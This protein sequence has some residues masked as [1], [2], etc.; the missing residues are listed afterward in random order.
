MSAPHGSAAEIHRLLAVAHNTAADQVLLR[1][2]PMLDQ[3]H[4]RSVLETLLQRRRSA[5]LTELVARCDQFSTTIQSD[6]Q[7]AVGKLEPAL[8]AA[9]QRDE[10]T[11]R[12]NAIRLIAQSGET[13]LM[14]LLSR[15]LAHRCPNTR[16]LAGKALLSFAER[17]LVAGARGGAGQPSRGSQNA[18]RHLAHA[19]TQALQSWELH[20]RPE[21]LIS[22]TALADLTESAIVDK[23]AQPRSRL[24]HAL[25]GLLSAPRDPR[26]APF[27]L[28]ALAI[29]ELRSDAARALSRCRNDAFMAAVIDECWVLKDPS[30]HRACA[31]VRE[32]QWLSESIDPLANLNRQQ[33]APSVRLIAA[34]GLPTDTK[35]TLLIDAF[36]QGDAHLRRAALWQLIAIDTPSSTS[37]LRRIAGRKGCPDTEIARRELQ[38]RRGFA[39]ALPKRSGGVASPSADVAANAQDALNVIFSDPEQTS[40]D[41]SSQALLGT[42][43]GTRY[44]RAKLAASDADDRTRALELIR[45][46]GLAGELAD[47][48]YRSSY[49]PDATVRSSAVMALKQI[50]SPEAIRILRRAL[51]DP[52]PRVQANAIEALDALEDPSYDESVER[53][54][55]A[56]AHR[57]RANAV[58][59]LLK[60]DVHRAAEALLE[61]LGSEARGERLSALWVVEQL[62]LNSI[63]EHIRYLAAHDTD[64]EVRRRAE[65]IAGVPT[66]R[67]TPVEQGVKEAES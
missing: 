1:A 11:S 30:V 41:H 29:P 38:R 34:T 13:H 45:S 23:L 9:L 51:Q 37:A 17:H 54:L 6:I 50:G 55:E 60:H 44:L 42:P 67:G 48:L 47:Q 16:E 61:M 58:K 10:F 40:A 46:A 25:R 24:A 31:S 2:L 8:R 53:L 59:A 32:L 22:A 63:S 43:E 12:R 5:P 20:L 15:A 27:I 65:A 52:D 64:A 19:L 7:Q 35:V 14:Y 56:P 49:D 21:V 4:C 57:V 66:R 26:L 39:T 62:S 28:R 36:V 18:G 3:P 33:A